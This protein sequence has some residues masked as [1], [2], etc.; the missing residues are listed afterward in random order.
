MGKPEGARS[1][2]RRRRR[3]EDGIK[4]DLRKI[5][6]EDVEWIHLAQVRDWWRAVVNAVMNLPVLGPRIYLVD[7]TYRPGYPFIPT[8]ICC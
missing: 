6:W 4:V 8:L 1:L 3:C 5:C 7:S 2:G